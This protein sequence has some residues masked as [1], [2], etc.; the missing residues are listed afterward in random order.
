MVGFYYITRRTKSATELM[1]CILA[2]R[3]VVVVVKKEQK[4]LQEEDILEVGRIWCGYFWSR[5]V[6]AVLE[7]FKRRSN[8]LIKPR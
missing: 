1:R 5:Y 2:A 4:G 8:L 3:R 6:V 7:S